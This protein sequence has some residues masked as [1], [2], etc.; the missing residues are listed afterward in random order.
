MKNYIIMI[1]TLVAFTANAQEPIKALKVGDKIPESFW[2]QEH[3]I[4]QNGKTTK[5]N[6]SAYKGK[7]LIL[8][9]WATWCGSCIAAMPKLHHLQ[10]QFKDQLNI[11]AV[12]NTP[13]KEA[14][15]FL[16]TNST[17]KDL[18]VVTITADQALK[19]AFPH[20]VIPHLIWI[21]ADGSYHAATGNDQVNFA[22]IQ[23][24][25]KGDVQSLRQ[26]IDLAKGSHIFLQEQLLAANVIQSY[27]LFFKGIY[28]GL[29][30]GHKEFIAPNKQL[31]GISCTNLPLI[32]IYEK[33][34]YALFKE[35]GIAYT[36][37]RRVVEGDA[38]V[39]QELVKAD[40]HPYSFNDSNDLYSYTRRGAPMAEFTFYKHMLTELN[41]NSSY[42]GVITKRATKCLVLRLTG[43]GNALKTKGGEP[44]QQW[45]TQKDTYITNYPIAYMVNRINALSG[46]PLLII[47]ETGFLDKVDIKIDGQLNQANLMAS[48]SNYGLALTEETR[49][50]DMFVINSNPKK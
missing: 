50:L 24:L 46:I 15:A 49:M 2:Q 11:L 1:L 30:A 16:N 34:I 32:E 37:K 45:L 17:V 14:V 18:N 40:E 44:K 4:Y 3:T 12:T 39:Q 43:D 9:F 38:I 7:L 47:D 21:A 8:D 42:N 19:Q 41:A 48:L 28:D 10:E 33:C 29:P 31:T 22:N 20:L 13:T 6:L 36:Y 35:K 25:L 27:S 5:Q 26:K 23:N